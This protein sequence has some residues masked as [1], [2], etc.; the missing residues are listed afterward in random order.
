MKVIDGTKIADEILV[1]LENKI[2]KS[3]IIPGLAV[4]LIGDNDA[5]HIYVNLKEEAAEKVGINFKKFLFDKNVD[6]KIIIEKINKLNQDEN[7]HGIV[8]QLPLPGKFDTNKII[9]TISL[10]K[11]ADGFRK[12][13]LVKCPV[14]PLAIIKMIGSVTNAPKK[15]LVIAKSDRFGKTMVEQL[16]K[17]GFRSNYV[18]YTEIDK[19]NIKNYDVVVTACGIPNM[20]KARAVKNDAVIIDGGIK[21]EKEKGKVLGD[22]DFAS[23]KN[24]NCHVSPVPYGVGPVTVACLL[25]S[26][27]NLRLKQ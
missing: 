27:Y 19:E 12:N 9:N 17:R 22:V 18:I 24:T 1:E 6:E 23:F 5:S 4:V 7:I 14:F 8:V 13:S 15:V 16:D 21:K 11:D 2:K 25:E 26:V 10:A 3:G 20:I